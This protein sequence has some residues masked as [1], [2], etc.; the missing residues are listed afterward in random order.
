[1]SL[2]VA[3]SMLAAGLAGSLH[4]VGMCGPILLGFSE[5]DGTPGSRG[6]TAWGFLWYHAGRI[7]T[8]AVL[9]LLAG[10]LGRKAAV[11]AALLGWQRPVSVALALLVVVSGLLLY[12]GARAAPGTGTGGTCTGLL[13]RLGWLRTLAATRGALPRLLLGASDLTEATLR[14]EVWPATA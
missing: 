9:G 5:L 2:W 12:G 13:G 6:R 1:M 3:L 14:A 4:C 8:Y 7:W 10:T 11:G